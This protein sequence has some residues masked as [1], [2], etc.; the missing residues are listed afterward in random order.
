MIK[1][2]DAESGYYV[3]DK[4]IIMQALQLGYIA[5]WMLI[6]VATLEDG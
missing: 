1:Y 4:G 5:R 2:S 3:L 6:A